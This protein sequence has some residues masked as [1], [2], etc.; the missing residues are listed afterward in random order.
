MIGDVCSL[1]AGL[2]AVGGLLV[3]SAL[4][5]P[6]RL[7]SGF[8]RFCAS[9]SA[10]AAGGAGLLGNNPAR[11][12][13][14]ALCVVAL[15]WY[16]WLRLARAENRMVSALV[17]LA[18]GL[19]PV[20]WT[21]TS[22]LPREGLAIAGSVSSALLL[23]TVAVTMTLGH[24]Y[25]VD[26]SLS[27]APLRDGALWMSAAVAMR[28]AVVG[29]VLGLGGFGV[30]RIERL[31]DLVFSTYALFFLF[32]AVVGLGAPVLLSGLIWQTVKIR[33]TQSATGLLYV[34]L[35]LVLFGELVSSFL[36]LST[37]YPL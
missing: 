2:L 1:F 37:G 19:A 8:V 9:A 20:V 4:T 10:L 18:A 34:A 33:S 15:V 17:A 31:A 32:R 30:L 11:W 35:I 26:T 28:V 21:F 13:W 22:A 29:L 25:L 16:A 23:G 12:V 27:I 36:F 6:H 24:W 3:S 5:L 7:P 14:A